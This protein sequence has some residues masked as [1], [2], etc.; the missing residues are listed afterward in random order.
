[1]LGICHTVIVEE[2]NGEKCYNSSSP[3]ELALVNAARHFGFHFKERD[4]DNN[5]IIEDNGNEIKY[6][7]L[8]VIEFN[9]TRKRMTAIIKDPAGKIRVL[10]KGADSIIIPR[11]K[12]KQRHLESTNKFLENYAKEGLRTLILAEKEVSEDFYFK[13]NKKYARACVALHDREEK[14]NV[15]AEQIENQF[16]LVGSTAIED[17]LQDNL[18]ETIKFIKEAEIKLWVLTGDKIETAINI[19]YSC[20]LLTQ[21]MEMFIVD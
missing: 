19:G 3:D 18:A 7:L 12:E 21:D 10:C 6:A 5:V 20:Q 15:I 8:N 13:W 14:M 17:K 9:S 11:L 2:K 4:E 16:D 1:M